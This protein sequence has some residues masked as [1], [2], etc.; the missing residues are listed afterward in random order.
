[1]HVIDWDD[2][3]M[4]FRGCGPHCRSTRRS[5]TLPSDLQGASS[6]S[7]QFGRVASFKVQVL[8]PEHSWSQQQS[9]EGGMLVCVYISVSP[10][11]ATLIVRRTGFARLCSES[12]HGGSPIHW[13]LPAGMNAKMLGGVFKIDWICRYLPIA[14][15]MAFFLKLKV[16]FLCDVLYWSYGLV[17]GVSCHS[18]KLPTFPTH[19]M[20]TS[21]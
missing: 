1:M 16:F 3:W 14:K 8:T 15:S 17:A 20:S 11:M 12:H 4:L 18:P 7:S 21:L 9:T 19:G 10:L 2:F 5:W 6:L 13:V